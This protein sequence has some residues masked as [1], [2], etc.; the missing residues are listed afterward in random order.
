MLNFNPERERGGGGG[1]RGE[2]GGRGEREREGEGREGER[3]EGREGERRGGGGGRG[4]KGREVVVVCWL[5]NVPTKCECISGTDPLR[6]LYV[7]PR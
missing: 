7:L 1:E 5:L 6:K 3:G 4:E 2:R